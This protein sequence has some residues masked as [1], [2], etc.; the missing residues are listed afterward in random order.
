MISLFVYIIWSDRKNALKNE[1]KFKSSLKKAGEYSLPINDNTLIDLIKEYDLNVKDII[2]QS[3]DK[4]P[5]QNTM[6]FKKGFMENK[7]ITSKTGKPYTSINGF[8]LDNQKIAPGKHLLTEL[9]GTPFIVPKCKNLS[10]IYLKNVTLLNDLKPIKFYDL[11]N[12]KKDTTITDTL[13]ESINYYYFKMNNKKNL[14]IYINTVSQ[15]DEYYFEAACFECYISD[16]QESLNEL[17]ISLKKQKEQNFDLPIEL[18]DPTDLSNVVILEGWDGFNQNRK[19]RTIVP[20]AFVHNETTGK[21]QVSVLFQG[22][23][24]VL[25]EGDL[26]DQ[27]KILKINKDN[28]LFEKNGKI[29]TLVMSK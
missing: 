8:S 1:R 14:E 26:I 9:T 11:S 12:L 23:R 25:K 20:T 21:K 4:E 18:T 27:G 3:K 2:K 10:N 16:L 15:I 29:D 22:E 24:K 7:K 19:F 13:L 6:S 5:S 28:L 17:E